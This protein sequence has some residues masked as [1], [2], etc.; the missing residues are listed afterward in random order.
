MAENIILESTSHSSRDVL[1]SSPVRGVRSLS[2]SLEHSR[3]STLEHRYYSKVFLR[4]EWDVQKRRYQSAYVLSNLSIL[5]RNHAHS[6]SILKQEFIIKNIKTQVWTLS[7]ALITSLG[8]DD[9]FGDW[10]DQ[11][12]LISQAF[13]FLILTAMYGVC[14]HLLTLE[15]YKSAQQLPIRNANLV[16]LTIMVCFG[17]RSAI[18]FAQVISFHGKWRNECCT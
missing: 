12:W 4:N 15:N 10:S 3:I 5:V 6:F 17:S 9:K 16:N 7:W 1:F 18:D 13:V 2:H 11:V 14:A 8:D